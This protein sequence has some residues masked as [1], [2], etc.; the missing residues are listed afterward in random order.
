MPVG[1][2][3]KAAVSAS[4]P[5]KY[6]TVSPLLEWQ[7]AERIPLNKSSAAEYKYGPRI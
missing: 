1:S 5:G 7:M 6:V 3:G 2:H 4:H